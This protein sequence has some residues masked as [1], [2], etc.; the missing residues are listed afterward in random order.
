MSRMVPSH[1]IYSL[2]TYWAPPTHGTY[3]PDP[4][5]YDSQ[6]IHTHP[7]IPYAMGVQPGTATSCPSPQLLMSPS[8]GGLATHHNMGGGVTP[9]HIVMALPEGGG[10]QLE[11]AWLFLWWLD[12]CHH[13]LQT[14]QVC[15]NWRRLPS[16]WKSQSP[17]SQT[18]PTNP[19]LPSRTSHW[20]SASN[21]S[22]TT[23]R[24]STQR[25]LLS[26]VFVAPLTGLVPLAPSSRQTQTSLQALVGGSYC[27]LL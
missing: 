19:T 6:F 14:H 7:P 20:T 17:S 11:A 5:G 26:L 22:R 18:S 1:P 4:D 16:Q 12:L 15:P 9:A 24:G 10:I 23:N 3:C 21:L 25:K 13:P 27:L 2:V 8:M